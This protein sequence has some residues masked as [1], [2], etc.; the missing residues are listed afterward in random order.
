MSWWERREDLEAEHHPDAIRHRLE[1]RG[2]HSY[3][4]DA[5]L[6]AI[7]GCVTTFAVV[8][9]AAGGGFSA[10]VAVVLG[11]SSLLADGFSMAVSNYQGTR[12]QLELVDKAR[13]SEERHIDQVPEGEREEIRQI[14]ARKGF[15]GEV[16]EEIVETITQD[17]KLWVDTMLT[18]ELELPLDGPGPLR[19]ALTTFG[20]FLAVGLIPLLPFLIR[21]LSL[22]Q[23]LVISAVATAA[24]FFGIGMFKGRVVHRPLF[25]SGL[26]TLVTGSCAAAL[27]YFVASWLRHTYGIN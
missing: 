12:S 9:G 16:L 11:F 15:K 23:M 2:N 4:G 7:D 20:A 8:A 5:V 22:S 21:G 26:S 3:L 18:E 1:R 17:R 6:G 10:G 27:A 19:A 24:A 13:R 25:T 14:F